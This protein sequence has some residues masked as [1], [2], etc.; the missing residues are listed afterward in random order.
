M[1]ASRFRRLICYSTIAGALSACSSHYIPDPK[2]EPI[3]RCSSSYVNNCINAR[4]MAEVD[5]KSSM[6]RRFMGIDESKEMDV[7]AD[8][9]ISAKGS[10]QCSRAVASV[11]GV[12][13]DVTDIIGMDMR[14]V[15]APTVESDCVQTVTVRLAI[16]KDTE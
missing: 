7:V 1:Q 11:D 10:I 13:R 16:D 3:M 2:P 8:L 15:P 4:V 5:S 6:I 12:E 9:L 14:G